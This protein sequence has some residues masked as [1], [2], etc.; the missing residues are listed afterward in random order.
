M[1]PARPGVGIVGF[2]KMEEPLASR[3][4]QTATN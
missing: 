1:T 4:P 3:R 2:R